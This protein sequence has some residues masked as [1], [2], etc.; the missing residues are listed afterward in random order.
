MMIV[1]SALTKLL[2]KQD[3]CY[4]DQYCTLLPPYI[5]MVCEFTKL[6][7]PKCRVCP[8]DNGTTLYA[9]CKHKGKCHYKAARAALFA[10]VKA[11]DKAALRYQQHKEEYEKE[12]AAI[13]KQIA[14]WGKQ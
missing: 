4:A 1:S 3:R 10:A 12:Y 9:Y 11:K 13:K 7:K 2:L 5:R 6:L 14:E 8:H